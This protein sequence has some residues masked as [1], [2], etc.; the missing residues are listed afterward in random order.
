M[1]GEE[2]AL[3]NRVEKPTA[4]KTLAVATKTELSA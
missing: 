4:R 2:T 3:L 1:E